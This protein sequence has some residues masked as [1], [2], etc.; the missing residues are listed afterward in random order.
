MHHEAGDSAEPTHHGPG[1]FV[2]RVVLA[3]P[4]GRLLVATSRRHR[5]GLAPHTCPTREEKRIPPTRPEA[6]R[7]G[8]APRRLG[9]WTAVLFAAGS[10][11]FALGGWAASWPAVSSLASPRTAKALI[12]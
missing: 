5:K 8:W 3:L 4:H 9:L 7:H 10:A 12:E 6:W 11:G 2:T 1:P